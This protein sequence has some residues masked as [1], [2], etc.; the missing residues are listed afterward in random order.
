MAKIDWV[1][2]KEVDWEA[3]A[4]RMGMGTLLAREI[5]GR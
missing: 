3:T 5:E 4:F 2:L 1:G